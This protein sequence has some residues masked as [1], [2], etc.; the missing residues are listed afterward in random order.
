[1]A[2]VGVSP[3][4]IDVL[5]RVPLRVGQRVH[6]AFELPR[7]DGSSLR[8]D[9]PTAVKRVE[10]HGNHHSAYLRF[11]QLSDTEVDLITEYCAVV[12]GTRQ[13]RDPDASADGAT[14]E[15][16]AEIIPR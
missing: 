15:S 9:C 3:F 6:I 8:F 14:M 2:V 4:G 16:V 7:A 10:P 13:L 11:A 5:S 1:M 12:A